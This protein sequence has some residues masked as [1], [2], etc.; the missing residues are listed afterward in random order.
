MSNFIGR[1]FHSFSAWIASAT[2]P[3]NPLGDNTGAG[4]ISAAAGA[5]QRAFHNSSR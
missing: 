2:T 4:K 5:Q 3:P 1:A